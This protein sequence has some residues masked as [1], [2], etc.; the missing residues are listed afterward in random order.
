MS[1][2]PDLGTMFVRLSMEDAGFTPRVRDAYM[3]LVRDAHRALDETAVPREGRRVWIVPGRI[4][5]LGKHVDYAGGRSLL[6]T[7]QRGIVIVARAHDERTLVLRDAR[8]R[9]SLTV[10]FDGPPQAAL[11]WTV[12]PKTVL[13]RLQLNF[14]DA[15][16]GADIAIASNLPPAAGVSSSS[17]LVVGL[18]LALSALSDLPAQQ[19]W[20]DSI[21][22][23]L[24][25]AGYAG[26]LEN[27][28]GFRGLPG[29]LG[30][31]T[32]GG[33]QDQTAILCCAPGQVDVFAWSPVRHE[34]TVPWP[35]GYS[36]VIG[37]SGVVAAKTGAAKERYNRAART[38]HLLV[39]L[40]NQQ[41]GSARTLANVFEQASGVPDPAAVPDVLL[42]L[43]KAGGDDEFSGDHLQRR[44]RQ[45]HDE[46]YRLVPGA[47]DALAR[48]A[49]ADFGSLVAASQLGAERALENQITE[50]VSLVRLAREL[51][52]VASSAFGAGFGGSVWAMVPTADADRF[53]NSWRDRYGEAHRGPGR[54]AQFF[55]TEPSAPAFELRGGGLQP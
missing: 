34:R 9:E 49:L 36:F 24:A 46:T 3:R 44:L 41:G 13:H 23:R 26:A 27:G 29:E 33:A 39:H 17:A 32:M 25:L 15:V 54:R 53:A 31:G 14:A 30:V 22:D 52:A 48:G 38:V 47:A 19:A 18:T 42:A 37:V 28:I 51:G 2:P 5:V 10:P 4:E 21:P 11:P 1:V 20:K 35:A 45:F 8:R 55:S 6:C 50:T 12:Y 43:A 16:R 40:W 7:V